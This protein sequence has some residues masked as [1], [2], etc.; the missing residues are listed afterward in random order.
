[1]SADCNE[2]LDSGR[3]RESDEIC[4]C[5]VYETTWR[6]LT[7]TRPFLWL[8]RLRPKALPSTRTSLVERVSFLGD[9]LGLG[10]IFWS[11][12]TAFFRRRKHFTINIL[13]D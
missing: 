7:H 4:K 10:F 2:D 1:M 8:A 6:R 13:L 11:M 3:A 9:Y 12:F 5:R